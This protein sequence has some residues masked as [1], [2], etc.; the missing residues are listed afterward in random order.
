MSHTTNILID[1]P[2]FQFDSFDD[3]VAPSTLHHFPRLQDQSDSSTHPTLSADHSLPDDP[4]PAIADVPSQT[5]HPTIDASDKG[6]SVSQPVPIRS[7]AA[8]DVE[9]DV[10]DLS[11]F[12]SSSSGHSNLLHRYSSPAPSYFDSRPAPCPLDDIV[13]DISSF[14][15]GSSP[16]KE[17]PSPDR[18]H[19]PTLP[20]LDKGKGRELPPTLPPLAFSPTEFGY[21]NVLWPSPGTI[22]PPSGPSSYGSGYGSPTRLGFGRAFGQPLNSANDPVVSLDNKKALPTV[23]RMPSRRRSLSSLSIRST[24]SLTALSMTRIKAGASKIPDN[25]ARK[26]FCGKPSDLADPPSDEIGGAADL[27]AL[28]VDLSDV[29]QS[30]C[31]TP[32]RAD[33]KSRKEDVAALK[34]DPCLGVDQPSPRRNHGFKVNGRSNSS[35]LPFSTIGIVA[36]AP[37]NVLMPRTDTT[38][39][40]FDETPRELR[41]AIV[42]SLL[43][44]HEAE[45]ERYKAEGKWTALRAASSRG[46]WVGKDR[47]RRELVKLSRVSI[48]SSKV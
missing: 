33:L 31:L 19:G 6:K 15:Y 21:G 5:P 43:T 30:N 14:G 29:G 28:D 27:R 3:P 12:R 48:N 1:E 24:H 44:L 7:I 36:L 25:L 4:P 35:P 20:L 2:L 42:S 34:L 18:L 38:R 16:W 22:A 26:L 32:W 39:N 10:F 45:Y 37:S 13:H 23:R 17:R 41:L 8:I 47:G 46:K 11:P 9:H 40:Y